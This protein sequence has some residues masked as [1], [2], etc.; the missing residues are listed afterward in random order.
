V[1]AAL[2]GRRHALTPEIEAIFVVSAVF[3]KVFTINKKVCAGPGE[4]GLSPI[5]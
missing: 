2:S 4:S 1:L 3:R 5:D